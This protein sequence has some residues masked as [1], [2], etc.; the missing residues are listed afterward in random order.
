MKISVITTLY[1]YRHYL[2]DCIKSFLDQNFLES[3]M[4][5]VNDGS[6]DS[7]N[8]V[9]KKISDKRISFID[10]GKNYGYS[11]AKNVGIKQSKG[12]YLVM[13]DADDMLTPN[14]L[15]I[16]YRKI[17]EGYDMVHG[18]ALDLKK[19]KTSISSL[20]KKWLDSDKQKDSYK[21]VHAQSVML[22]RDLHKEIG[23]Y[24]TDLRFKS[25]REMW[26][27]IFYRQYIIGF[28]NDPVCLYRIHD[29]QM[30]KSKAKAK[31]N[32]VLALEVVDKI[33]RRSKNL[34]DVEML[35]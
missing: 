25:D 29:N 27:R 7:P 8:K 4:I 22:R 3:E 18:P 9:M 10:L 31:I 28:V 12:E 26:G 14:S 5:I 1:N 2:E 24:D 16:R 21:Y 17:T 30:H 15:D 20:W 32:D 35:K 19:G 13:L 33:N 34:S 6:T 11:Y 23:L